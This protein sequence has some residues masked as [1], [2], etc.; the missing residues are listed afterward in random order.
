MRNDSAAS[1]LTV[2]T[3][4]SLSIVDVPSARRVLT[5]YSGKSGRN[6]EYV[7]RLSQI[8]RGI[9]SWASSVRPCWPRESTGD[10]PDSDIPQHCHECKASD[11]K[12]IDATVKCNAGECGNRTLCE[13]HA[14]SHVERK[15]SCVSLINGSTLQRRYC[16]I[17]PSNP[18]EYHCKVDNEVVCASCL[19]SGS[20]RGHASEGLTELKDNLRDLKSR[21]NS[22][23]TRS[24]DIETTLETR[25]KTLQAVH[26][27]SLHQAKSS[28]DKSLN[29]LLV[30]CTHAMDS[31]MKDFNTQLDEWYV[32]SGQLSAAWHLAERGLRCDNVLEVST[33]VVSCRA[34]SGMCGAGF[35][36]PAVSDCPVLVVNEGMLQR[37]IHRAVRMQSHNTRVSKF[38]TVIGGTGAKNFVS[39]DSTHNVIEVH[40]RDIAGEAV[41][42]LVRHNVALEAFRVWDDGKVDEG[43]SVLRN[44]KVEAHASDVGRFQITYDVYDVSCVALWLCIGG[45]VLSEGVGG[46][47]YTIIEGTSVHARQNKELTKLNVR[48]S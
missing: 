30:R 44:L 33:T 35:N 14:R 19:L 42:G 37:G 10:E 4:L 28:V 23:G 15:H 6:V 11:G 13:M 22:E 26:E 9:F 16:D 38:T 25:R 3:H 31:R 29:T 45:C 32:R 2:P 43:C 46:S 18:L 40:V 47:H 39:G 48:D 20:H 41:D 12:T 21:F 36:G 27:D 24:S 34:M 1:V 8:A 7:I 17:H 5:A